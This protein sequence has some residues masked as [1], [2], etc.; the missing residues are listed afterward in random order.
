MLLLS[1]SYPEALE[2]KPGDEEKCVY[3]RQEDDVILSIVYNRDSKAW[4]GILRI[5]AHDWIFTDDAW[6]MKHMNLISYSEG[7]LFACTTSVKEESASFAEAKKQILRTLQVTAE[8][9]RALTMNRFLRNPNKILIA[10]RI[11]EQWADE[12]YHSVD[13]MGV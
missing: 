8:Y 13:D 3:L 9:I 4:R 5:P 10:F 6:N 2:G 12:Y 7:H 1:G 11:A